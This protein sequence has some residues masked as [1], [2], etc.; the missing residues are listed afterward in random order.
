MVENVE[1]TI[2]VFSTLSTILRFYVLAI[3][4][5]HLQ[6]NRGHC[7]K[8]NW[9]CCLEL[10]SLWPRS[11]SIFFFFSLRHVE[12]PGIQVLNLCFIQIISSLKVQ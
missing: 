2:I 4:I 10:F 5:H 7:T 1:K 9:I 11:N 8:K 3:T 12:A 6:S